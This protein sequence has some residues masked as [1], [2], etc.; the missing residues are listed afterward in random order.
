MQSNKDLKA[1]TQ[2]NRINM[3]KNYRKCGESY[4]KYMFNTE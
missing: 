2:Q 4:S 3:T 1:T